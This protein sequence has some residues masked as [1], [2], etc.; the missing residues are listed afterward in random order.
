MRGEMQVT[1]TTQVSANARPRAA[2]T[3]T[4]VCRVSGMPVSSILGLAGLEP[5]HIT[6]RL[7]AIEDGLLDDRDRLSAALF[8]AIGSVQDKRTRSTLLGVRRD[9]YN[10]RRPAPDRDAL[11]AA[12]PSEV[13]AAVRAADSQLQARDDLYG[14]FRGAHDRA[15]AHA[16]TRFKD[17]L[18][19]ADF[20]KGLA[21]SSQS[22]F[23]NLRR[24]RSARTDHHNSR[25][26]QIERGLL[27]Y[28]TRMAT[29]AT[30]F[31]MFCAVIGGEFVPATEASGPVAA[32]H[33]DP[34]V[35]RGTTR[36]NKRIYAALWAYLCTQ[37]NVRSRLTVEPNPTLRQVGDRLLYLTTVRGQEVFQRVPTSAALEVI[38]GLA[39]RGPDRSLA[40]LTSQLAQDPRCETDEPEARVYLDRLIDVGLLS[41]QGV[42][43]EQ[44]ANWAAPLAAF[45]GAVDDH[46]A[47]EAGRLLNDLQELVER[48]GRG[49]PADRAGM[50]ET[51]RLRLREGFV[52]LGAPPPPDHLSPLY[53][54]ATADARLRI[55]R[56]P[57]LGTALDRLAEWVS[58]TIP[59]NGFRVDMAPMRHFFD[60]Y[61]AACDAP[62]LVPLLTFYEDYYREHFRAHLERLQTGGGAGSE[63][64]YDAGNPFG[65]ET[66]RR[67]REAWAELTEAVRAAWAADPSAAE[68]TVRRATLESALATAGAD[69]AVAER[70]VAV[71]GQII[72]DS[73]G[74]ARIVVQGARLHCGYGKYFSRFL[75]LLPKRWQSSVYKENTR[76][77]R[78][79]LAEICGD[80]AFNANLHPPLLPWEIS[81]P[82]GQHAGSSRQISSV[83][84]A[85]SRD[86]DDQ[87][88]LVLHH[89]PSGRRVRPIDLG[90]LNPLMRPPLYQLLSRFSTMGAFEF[91][92]PWSPHAPDA[93]AGQQAEPAVI[94][95]P[96]LTYEGALVL[97]RRTWQVPHQL[98]PA[99]A[100]GELDAEYFL[101]VAR[102]R[103]KHG[104]PERVYV[105]VWAGRSGGGSAPVRQPADASGP[106][107]V[108]NRAPPDD[109]P[110]AAGLEEPAA[111]PE[112]SAVPRGEP[113]GAPSPRGPAA[114]ERHSSRDF[115]KPQFIDF[116]NPL[117]VQLFAH[118][119]GNLK[120]FN[121]V[122]EECL[123][124]TDQLPVGPDGPHAVELILQVGFPA[125][126]G[127]AG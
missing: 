106:D 56:T 15:L 55:M 102:W 68:V 96:R 74:S 109:G 94:C 22:L 39:K 83:D 51:I 6:E 62:R 29:K 28:F 89:V 60:T 12:L 61:Y 75:Y 111:E 59:L 90:F 63:P 69:V 124:A 127:E 34:R 47:Q 48:Y 58:L 4:F 13:V 114:Q 117:L 113:G 108:V 87:H 76:L 44:E 116:A 33:G 112:A 81:Y 20:Q 67:L 65:L 77:A 26:E 79:L 125:G 31:G 43:A 23:D 99:R 54:D 70:S 53:E 95:R 38:L 88:A 32:F 37:P 104:I 93:P 97:A 64:A 42:V 122:I 123:P 8:T 120:Q 107:D 24:Y 72:A 100:S 11:C 118:L 121:I 45:L 35:K 105:R 9:L 73:Q 1:A 66:I 84:L 78:S 86:P 30:P 71:F 98:Y 80:A 41:L 10:L 27:R 46:A 14:Q 7:L 19:D 21:L 57:G 103:R 50:L 5:S 2:L 91:P 101:R 16:R 3:P 85:V 119:A 126:G 25:D 82:P 17:A 110:E 40:E 115:E 18:A 52:T 49:T 36:L 92:V